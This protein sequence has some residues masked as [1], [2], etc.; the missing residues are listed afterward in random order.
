LSSPFGG[1]NVKLRRR[2]D[3]SKINQL[4]EFAAKKQTGFFDSAQGL[5]NR[6]LLAS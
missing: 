4:N 2:E 6:G 3:E 5:I 1:T